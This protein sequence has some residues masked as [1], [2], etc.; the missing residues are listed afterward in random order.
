MILNTS[1]G[2]RW[3]LMLGAAAVTIATLGV[4]TPAEAY[5][6]HGYGWGPHVGIGFGFDDRIAQRRDGEGHQLD[7]PDAVRGGPVVDCAFER[8]GGT[9]W[10]RMRTTP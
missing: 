5:W 4:A 6:R 3:T 1:K 7:G 8:A 2:R 10:S 9:P